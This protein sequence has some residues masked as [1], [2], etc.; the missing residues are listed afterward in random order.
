VC[1]MC[2]RV[3]VRVFALSWFIS[4]NLTLGILASSPLWI[5]QRLYNTIQYNTIRWQTAVGSRRYETKYC[6]VLVSEKLQRFIGWAGVLTQKRNFCRMFVFPT[7]EL[8]Y[9]NVAAFSL[10]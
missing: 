8:T 2:T 6:S 7:G 4:C 5:A 3:R 1:V 9:R 10:F